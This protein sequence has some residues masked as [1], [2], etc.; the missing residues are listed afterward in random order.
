MCNTTNTEIE[1]VSL[2]SRDTKVSAPPTA[3]MNNL[4]RQEACSSSDVATVTPDDHSVGE[5]RYRDS[6]EDLDDWEPGMGL[7][8]DADVRPQSRRAR[9]AATSLLFELLVRQTA[10]IR[11]HV[12]ERHRQDQIERG[13]SRQ[14]AERHPL[15]LSADAIAHPRAKSITCELASPPSDEEGA[16]S[17][18]HAAACSGQSAALPISKAAEGWGDGRSSEVAT[19]TQGLR[20]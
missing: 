16:W 18:E 8:D 6:P 4:H 20:C 7:N 1:I 11:A 9:L 2:A 19:S 10:I 3:A 5:K 14:I 15:T 13:I 17:Q 12:L